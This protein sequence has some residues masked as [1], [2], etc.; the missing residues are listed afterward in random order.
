MVKVVCE[1]HQIGYYKKSREFVPLANF[2]L[3][4]VHQVTYSKELPDTLSDTDYQGFIVRVTQKR[5]GN[6]EEG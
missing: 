5:R 3:Q 2:G 6:Y 4:L 1:D